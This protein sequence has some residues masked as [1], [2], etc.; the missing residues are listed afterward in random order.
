MR[1]LERKAD[2]GGVEMPPRRQTSN[3]FINNITQYTVGASVE[4]LLLDERSSDVLFSV[5]QRRRTNLDDDNRRDESFGGHG[6][7]KRSRFLWICSEMN[8]N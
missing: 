3:G 1:Y 2:P 8:E 6:E 4:I 7:V 5:N